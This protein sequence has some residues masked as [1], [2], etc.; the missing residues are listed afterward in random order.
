[1]LFLITQLWLTS[2]PRST[3]FLLETGTPDTN[4]VNYNED[5]DVGN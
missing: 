4:G 1:M 3:L 5:A 2:H